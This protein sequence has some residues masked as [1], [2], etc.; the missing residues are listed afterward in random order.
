MKNK[1]KIIVEDEDTIELDID[2]N[3]VHEWIDTYKKHS[4]LLIPNQKTI[5]EVI[6][7]MKLKYSMVEDKSEKYTSVVIK[8]ITMN[9]VL[10]KRIPD[11]K[12]LN[13]T[14]FLIKNEGNSS[15][16]YTMREDIYKDVP[17]IVGM[18][19][20]TGFVSVEGSKELSDEITAFQGLDSDELTN[21]YLVSNY[22]RCL[23][24]YNKLDEVLHNSK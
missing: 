10:A 5:T 15:D 19:S 21:F 9:K 7:Y 16:L 8:N 12:E 20:E 24:K 11:G 6:K 3:L 13:P 2:D 14:V 18:E 1:I 22:V 17:I 23:K 4:P